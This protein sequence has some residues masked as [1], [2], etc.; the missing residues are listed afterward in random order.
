MAGKK[1][2]LSPTL[3]GALRDALSAYDT[4]SR[5]NNTKIMEQVTNMINDMLTGPEET[6]ETHAAIAD[7]LLRPAAYGI[8]TTVPPQIRDN[9]AALIIATAMENLQPEDFTAGQKAQFRRLL[10]S[11]I[12]HLYN[13]KVSRDPADRADFEKQR[14]AILKRITDAVMAGHPPP[15]DDIMVLDAI[16]RPEKYDLRVVSEHR[17]PGRPAER[18]EARGRPAARETRRTV[19]TRK[20]IPEEVSVPITSAR[21]RPP[22]RGA[23]VPGVNPLPTGGIPAPKAESPASPYI[24]LGEHLKRTNSAAYARYVTLLQGAL[25][26]PAISDTDKRVIMDVLR[27]MGE[28]PEMT[29]MGRIDVQHYLSRGQEGATELYTLLAAMM[30]KP[31]HENTQLLNDA[32]AQLTEAA[33]APNGFLAAGL[34]S[35]LRATH[36]VPAQAQQPPPPPAAAPQPAVIPEVPAAPV[37]QPPPR[38]RRR[39]EEEVMPPIV[40]VPIIPEGMSPE[41]KERILKLDEIRRT[42]RVAWKA[43]IQSLLYDAAKAYRENPDT[44]MATDAVRILAAFQISASPN[45]L[46]MISP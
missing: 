39:R 1:A 17:Q 16:D 27:G 33:K 19:T 26:S 42:N 8:T 12:Q 31:T 9:A 20:E 22:R 23:A 15:S 13:E 36:P 11:L 25:V 45:F 10:N 43:A 32:L 18:T 29:A 24:A 4:A 30:H 46:N 6:A 14:R 5:S 21:G 41:L 38:V 2:V 40:A 44:Y 35:R 7:L 3:I 28:V 34:L 37:E